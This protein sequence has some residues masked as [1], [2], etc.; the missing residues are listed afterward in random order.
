MK[1]TLA[2]LGW[3]LL[4]SV[5]FGAVSAAL[6]VLAD[7][8]PPFFPSAAAEALG[9]KSIGYWFIALAAT[10]IGSWTW[11][12]KWL[13]KQIDTQRDAHTRLTAELIGYLKTDHAANSA[14]VS[15]NNDL[16]RGVLEH[17]AASNR[18]A[19]ET[20]KELALKPHA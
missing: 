20:A 15:Q 18:T 13:I 6:A 11:I 7:V 16:M 2:I 1:Q 10:A 5:T 9:G 3:V 4:P 12:V 14:I 8:T 19:H 17:L